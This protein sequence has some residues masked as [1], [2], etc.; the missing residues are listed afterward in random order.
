M[1]QI[2]KATSAD[3]TT[4]AYE[5]FGSGPVAVVVGGAFCD[6][7]AFRDVAQALGGLGF[8]GVT[9]DR[10]GRGDSGDTEPYAV[11]REIEDL[12]S[13]I[14]VSGETDSPAY[15]FGV[16]SGGALVI[17]AIAAGAPVEKGSALEVPYRTAAWPPAP[18]DYIT[19]LEGFEAKGDRAGIVRYFNNEVVGMPPEMVD[20]MVGTPMWDALLS[21]AYT[22]KY[23]GFCLGGDEQ[24][25]PAE[26]FARVTVPFLSVCSS[27]TQLPWLHDAAGVVA[28]ALPNGTAVELPGEFHQV[29]AEVLAPALA[30]FFRS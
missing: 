15:V 27:G 8:T 12:T 4:I 16:S 5:A 6:R 23:D 30:E 21:M 2:H 9:Y 10:R 3:G 28:T 1:S 19:T 18:A 25:I 20:G 14:R 29:R 22:V 11:A 24:D 7:G 26:T 17:E 13:V